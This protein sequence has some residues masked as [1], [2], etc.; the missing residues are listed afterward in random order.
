MHEGQNLLLLPPFMTIRNLT[1]SILLQRPGALNDILCSSNHTPA[2]PLTYLHMYGC[3]T[4]ESDLN[5][6]QRPHRGS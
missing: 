2:P 3:E 6:R 4:S 1:G 5:L